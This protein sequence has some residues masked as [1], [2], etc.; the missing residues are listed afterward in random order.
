[1]FTHLAVTRRRGG[2]GT[3]SDVRVAQRHG[4]DARAGGAP[5]PPGAAG[6]ASGSVSPAAPHLTYAVRR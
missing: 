6:S 2:D 5:G 4:A 1:M 3:G